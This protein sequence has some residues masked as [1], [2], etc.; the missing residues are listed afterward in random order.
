[1]IQAT[2]FVEFSEKK[3][4]RKNQMITYVRSALLPSISELIMRAYISVKI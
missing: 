4:A 2:V 3:I 1:M